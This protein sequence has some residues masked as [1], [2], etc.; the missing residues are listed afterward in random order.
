[1]A[2]LFLKVY[3]FLTE[4]LKL[5]LM[6]PKKVNVVDL[7]RYFP[8]WWSSLD[9]NRSPILDKQPWIAFAAIRFL[10]SILRKD[11]RVYE[12]GSGGSTLF[13]AARVQEV[14]STEHNKDWY[15]KVSEEIIKKGLSNC[16]LRL[17]EPVQAPT[18]VQNAS[19][20]DSYSSGDEQY[21]GMSFREYA[22]SINSYPDGYFDIVFIDGRARPSCFK[23]AESKIKHGGYLILDNAETPYY[24][25]IHDAAGNKK[26][27]KRDYF[28]LFPYLYHFSETCIWQ[29]VN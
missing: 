1:M 28:G 17:F 29:K 18:A 7:A 9:N 14:I 26:W 21:R 27:K 2:K 12:Y 8:A 16:N 23:H 10:E 19:D 11:M 24:S 25:F 6:N 22:S 5:L 4:T 3:S 13:F 20:P 15:L